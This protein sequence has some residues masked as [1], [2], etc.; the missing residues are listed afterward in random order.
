MRLLPFWAFTAR[1]GVDCTFT[2][3][4]PFLTSL[5][6]GVGGTRHASATLPPGKR[7]GTDRTGGCVGCREENIQ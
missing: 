1:S 2:F 4:L 6:G 5:V 3:P 7:V